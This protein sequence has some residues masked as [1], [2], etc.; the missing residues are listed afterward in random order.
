MKKLT[1]VFVLFLCGIVFAQ[2]QQSNIIAVAAVDRT[3]NSQI[4]QIAARA[5]YYLIFDRSGKLMEVLSNPFRDATRGAGPKVAGLLIEKNVTVVVAGDFGHKMT[6]ALDEKV[7][8]H[9]K[10][11]GVVQKAIQDLLKVTN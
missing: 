1:I 11:T 8:S 10:A 7:I 9:L 6:I 5:P 2:A 3:E 4:S